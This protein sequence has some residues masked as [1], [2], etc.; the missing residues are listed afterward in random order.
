[1]HLD[2]AP[3]SWITDNS[4]FENLG[5]LMAVRFLLGFPGPGN[6][7]V[8]LSWYILDSLTLCTISDVAIH[9]VMVKLEGINNAV[10]QKMLNIILEDF[11]KRFEIG[12]NKMDIQ[13]DNKSDIIEKATRYFVIT[14]QL[15]KINQFS[16]C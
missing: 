15:E 3:T 2:M 11:N 12:Y 4:D 5:K 9:E 7:S 13:L 1:M 10:S 16:K 8:P 14:C 6:W